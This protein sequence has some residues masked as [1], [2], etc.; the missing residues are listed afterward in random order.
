MAAASTMALTALPT[1]GVV[2]E[3]LRFMLLCNE[4]DRFIRADRN[5]WTRAMG[6]QPGYLGKMVLFPQDE[7]RLEE[8]ELFLREARNRSMCAVWVVVEWRSHAEWKAV[9]PALLGRTEAAFASMFGGNP[10]PQEEPAGGSGFSLLLRTPPPHGAQPGVVVVHKLE[11]VAC[12]D[13]A[14]FVDADNATYGRMLST[15]PGF[16]G[17]LLLASNTP[18]GTLPRPEATCNLWAHSFWT[19]ADTF[20]RSNEWGLEMKL[21]IDFAR[22]LGSE[23]PM[24]Q[25]VLLANVL[26]IDKADP[27]CLER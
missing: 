11:P 18:E 1:A 2:F 16:A 12:R 21:E 17:R 24:S 4:L 27:T 25:R 6:V 9:D 19:N 5:T 3:A 14:R 23:I 8:D 7:V 22:K 13:V 26:A 20:R 15:R 10:A